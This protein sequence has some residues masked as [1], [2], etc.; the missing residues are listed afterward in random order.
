MKPRRDAAIAPV[1]PGIVLLEALTLKN[2]GQVG[3]AASD[4][5]TGQKLHDTS[6]C[7]VTRDAF[8]WWEWGMPLGWR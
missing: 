3:V 1:W 4:E 7:I 8:A 5:K 2:G 6:P